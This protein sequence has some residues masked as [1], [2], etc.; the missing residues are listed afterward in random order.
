MY[1]FEGEYKSRPVQA[2]GGASKKV[3]MMSLVVVELF[4]IDRRVM[5]SYFRTPRT[6]IGGTFV[7]WNS[8]NHK[9]VTWVMSAFEIFF[10]FSM[11]NS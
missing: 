11:C 4:Q 6:F 3:K 9:S 5:G 2:F 8:K 7:P 10:L 1:S